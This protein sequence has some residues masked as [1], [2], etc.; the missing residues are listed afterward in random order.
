MAQMHAV[1]LRRYGA[2]DELIYEET[3]NVLNHMLARRSCVFG[4]Q[5]SDPVD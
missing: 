4:P 1:R 3:Q 2:A 5:A